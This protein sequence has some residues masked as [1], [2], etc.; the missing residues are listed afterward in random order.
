MHHRKDEEDVRDNFLEE[1]VDVLK[2]LLGTFIINGFTA[3][4]IFDKFIDKSRVVDAKFKQENAIDKIKSSKRKTVFIDIDGVL[5]TWPIDYINF[6]NDKLGTKY[7]TLPEL[8]SSTDKKQQYDL[9]TEYRLTGQ[10]KALGIIP[11]AK[12]ML[13]KLNEFYNI[14]LLTARPY[15]KFFRIY[16]DTLEWLTN[17]GLKYDCIIFD[18]EKEKYII[19][20]FKDS[21][22]AFVI[23]DQLDNAKK[24][25]ENGFKVYLKYNKGLYKAGTTFQDIK[26]VVK[27]SDIT[28]IESYKEIFSWEYA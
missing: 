22:V 19:N 16:A 9:K 24:L 20:N 18:E 25:S 11:G 3:E 14:V 6:V 10:K 7:K 4:E 27:L 17:K 21:N 15:K 8:K 2:Y 1:G 23:D 12:D 26:D 5:A 13:E 28:V